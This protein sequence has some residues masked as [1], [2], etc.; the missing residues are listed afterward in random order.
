MVKS[1]KLRGEYVIGWS[2]CFAIKCGGA[3]PDGVCR[4]N[5]GIVTGTARNQ[6]VGQQ[7]IN[8]GVGANRTVVSQARWK[9][10]WM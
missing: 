4:L 1:A 5:I 8:L 7:S 10:I 6:H 2:P 9:N 3:A